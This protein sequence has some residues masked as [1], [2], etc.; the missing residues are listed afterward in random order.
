[1]KMEECDRLIEERGR[2][3]GRTEGENLKLIVQ[4]QKKIFKGKSLLETAEDLEEIPE[5]IRSLYT[6]VQE[7]PG[8]NPEDI[9]KLLK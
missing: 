7:N 6:L 5:D 4:I 9:L 3:E 8:K 1:M 2:K